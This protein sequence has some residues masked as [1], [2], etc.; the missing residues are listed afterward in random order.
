MR[1]LNVGFVCV[2]EVMAQSLKGIPC[3]S[4]IMTTFLFLLKLFCEP[5][6]SEK[7]PRKS[8]TDWFHL[9]GLWH[10]RRPSQLV[11]CS[12]RQGQLVSVVRLL[13]K[14]VYAAL[15]IKFLEMNR[16]LRTFLLVSVCIGRLEAENQPSQAAVSPTNTTATPPPVKTAT[17]TNAKQGPGVVS[18]AMMQFGLD[19]AR[20]TEQ[21]TSGCGSNNVLSPL[22]AVNA[23]TMVLS[24]KFCLGE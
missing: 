7:G 20:C 17:K 11:T 6:R 24:G 2:L 9:R 4:L 19:M 1:K 13:W 23:L 10:Q 3:Y 22:S 14:L 8:P 16:I 12:G 15:R 5:T 18:D 21:M